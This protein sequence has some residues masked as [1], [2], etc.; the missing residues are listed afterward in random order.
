MQGMTTKG[1]NTKNKTKSFKLLSL[2]LLVIAGECDA[3]D[4]GEGEQHKNKTKS[5]TPLSL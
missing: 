4:D 3:G 5:L 2:Y 1:S